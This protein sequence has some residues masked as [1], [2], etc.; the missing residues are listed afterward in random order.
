[1]RRNVR[2]HS[3]KTL[4]PADVVATFDRLTDPAVASAGASSFKGVLSKGGARHAG[5]RVVFELD[6]P[7]GTFPYL[8]SQI[9]YQAIILPSDYN[10]DFGETFNGTGPT[11]SARTGRDRA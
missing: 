8:L 9:T 3:G 1:M 5:T 10:G 6:A 4:T 11:S 7:T 2:F